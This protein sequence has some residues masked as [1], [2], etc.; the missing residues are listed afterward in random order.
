MNKLLRYAFFI[1]ATSP[2]FSPASLA[3]SNAIVDELKNCARIAAS[4]V[5][6]ACY[7]ALGRQVIQD[8]TS[9]QANPSPATSAST[10]SAVA[11]GTAT[12]ATAPETATTTAATAP[13]TATITAVAVPETAT[14]TVAP[15]EQP[16]M[17]DS[18]GGY[19]FEEKPL[20]H[21]D[22]DINTRIVQCQQ[23]LDKAWYF[24][25]ENGQVWK[26][27]DGKTRRFTS[28]DFPVVVSKDG[29]GYKMQIEGKG[30]KIRIS[31]R[32]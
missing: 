18:M 2:V 11:V 13:E 17:N 20:D 7:E 21:P 8:E 23:D 10:I 3:D 15:S 28:C 1:A 31:R 14:A 5:R 26:Q 16:S 19:K 22:N 6:I 4:D 30:A 32:K 9:A 27:V 24:K 12:A 25:F 29:F